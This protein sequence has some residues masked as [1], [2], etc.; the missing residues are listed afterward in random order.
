MEFSSKVLQT[1]KDNRKVFSADAVRSHWQRQTDLSHFKLLLDDSKY[2]ALHSLVWKNVMDSTDTK[3]YKY[4]PE[5][6]D[7]DDFAF[8]FK[9][10][11]AKA[12]MNG[13]GLVINYGGKHA[14]NVGLVYGDSGLGFHFIEPQQDN[15]IITGSKPCYSVSGPGLV[16]I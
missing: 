14:Y 11:L 4:I 15:W 5:F 12:A 3:S 6:R 9:G 2:Y 10:L 8:L 13:C 7:C 1:I 16:I